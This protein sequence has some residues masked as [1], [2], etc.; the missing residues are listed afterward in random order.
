MFILIFTLVGCGGGNKDEEDYG[1]Y[2]DGFLNYG[3]QWRCRDASNGQF[4]ANWM[5]A[6]QK[7]NDLKWPTSGV[8]LTTNRWFKGAA[9]HSICE[10]SIKRYITSKVGYYTFKQNNNDMISDT[11]SNLGVNIQIN[12]SQFWNQ[13]DGAARSITY[14]FDNDNWAVFVI[15]APTQFDFYNAECKA[16]LKDNKVYK[17]MLQI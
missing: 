14:Y 12:T 7:V 11:L 3:I 13:S 16:F 17:G 9:I 5:C 4:T 10:D 1:F 2:W 6:N 15:Q 8:P